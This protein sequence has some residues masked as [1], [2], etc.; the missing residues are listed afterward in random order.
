MKFLRPALRC[1][2]C[3]ITSAPIGLFALARY[4]YI[5]NVCRSDIAWEFLR[6]D[7][8]YQRVLSAELPC[9]APIPRA[10]SAAAHIH[11]PGRRFPPQCERWD[12]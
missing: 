9:A 11:P 3:A 8:A 4:A 5:L 2:G 6:R 1:L 7:P 12:L 10:A